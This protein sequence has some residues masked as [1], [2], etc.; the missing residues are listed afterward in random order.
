MLVLLNK[1][2]FDYVIELALC[3][4]IYVPSFL[5]INTRVQAILKFCLRNFRGCYVGIADG[6]DL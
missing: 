1:S 2:F 6:G 4:M 3:G 5:K